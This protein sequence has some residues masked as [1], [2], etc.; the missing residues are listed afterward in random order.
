ML[1]TY[2]GIERVIGGCNLIYVIF[3]VYIE[4]ALFPNSNNHFLWLDV[5]RFLVG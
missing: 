2:F 3:N 5:K 4:H 1:V